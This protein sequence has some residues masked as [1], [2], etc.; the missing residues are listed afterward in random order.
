MAQNTYADLA[1]ISEKIALREEVARLC[2]EL[3]RTEE[4]W[5]RKFLALSAEKEEMARKASAVVEEAAKG[6][7]L[8]CSDGEKME[9]AL[10][11]LAEEVESH[12]QKKQQQ[13]QQ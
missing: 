9:K 3:Q 8:V 7:T 6:T 1:H 5:R 13:Q 2:G 11:E 12:H 10:L 4:E